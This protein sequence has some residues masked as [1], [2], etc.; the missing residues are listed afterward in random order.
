[1]RYVDA[2]LDEYTREE[3]YRFYVTRSLQLAPQQKHL[4][5]SFMDILK[6]TKK[7]DTRSGDEIAADVISRAGLSF[8]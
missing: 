1:M 5:D 6:N 2:R 3:A 8:G 7:V 4:I